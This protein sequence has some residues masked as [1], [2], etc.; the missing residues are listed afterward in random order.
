MP[1]RE[2]AQPPVCQQC[3]PRAAGQAP[4]TA[5]LA[6][7]PRP[8]PPG[9]ASEPL[10]CP[11]APRS[12]EGEKAAFRARASA[13]SLE[14]CLGQALTRAGSSHV[15]GAFPTSFPG[16][17]LPVLWYPLSPGAFHAWERGKETSNPRAGFGVKRGL[18]R[19]QVGNPRALKRCG[20]CRARRA[21]SRLLPTA[22]AVW[23]SEGMAET[24]EAPSG[25]NSVSQCTDIL[26]Q[27]SSR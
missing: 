12:W 14:Q 21:K 23:S 22:G 19:M 18:H 11:A 7:S 1:R 26:C 15:P 4:D 16:A 9:T 5:P 24:A 3:Q 2:P 10:P 25:V 13:D 8:C 20:S 6:L 27:I 17:E